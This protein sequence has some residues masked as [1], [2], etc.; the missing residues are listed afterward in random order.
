MIKWE[1]RVEN[2]WTEKKPAQNSWLFCICYT[3]LVQK[4]RT[5]VDLLA[6]S[7]LIH[8]SAE[9]SDMPVSETMNRLLQ[10]IFY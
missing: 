9:C 4:K 7:I 3:S 2:Y 10:F 8:L 6:P 1:E 5:A